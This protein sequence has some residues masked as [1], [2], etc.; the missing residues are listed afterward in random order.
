MAS[1]KYS[2]AWNEFQTSACNTFQDLYGDEDFADVT[3]ACEDDKQ[4][5]AHKVILSSCSLFFKTILLKN[6]HQHPLLYLKGIKHVDLQSIIK[7]VYFGQTEVDHDC[8]DNFMTAAK[9]L[10]IKGLTEDIKATEP[11]DVLST[12][13][14]AVP[15]KVDYFQNSPFKKEDTREYQHLQ[16]AQAMNRNTD[17]EVMENSLE[18]FDDSREFQNTD[19]DK[20]RYSFNKN[21]E[22]MKTCDVCDYK[23]THTTNLEAHKVS[24]HSTGYACDKCSQTFSS[25]GSLTNHRRAIHEGIR[26]HCDECDFKSTQNHQLKS[27]KLRNH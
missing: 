19:E 2:L 16:E 23:T 5:K 18:I 8:L 17:D 9:E 22:G 20:Y 25:R 21:F 24:K 15:A 26:F 14:K 7:F 10:Q 6:P 12:E 4:I 27:H 11:L 1:E 3:L 13:I